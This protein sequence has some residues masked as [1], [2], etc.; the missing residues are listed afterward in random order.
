MRGV[1]DIFSALA[2]T[3]AG[4]WRYSKNDRAGG[5]VDFATPTNFRIMDMTYTRLVAKSDADLT[6]RLQALFNETVSLQARLDNAEAESNRLKSERRALTLKLKRAHHEISALVA[7]MKQRL[8]GGKT[9][10]KAVVRPLES[11]KQGVQPQQ[12]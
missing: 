4:K 7:E 12:I 9:F 2:K 8:P 1:W 11:A 5:A 10:M 6:S 3:A